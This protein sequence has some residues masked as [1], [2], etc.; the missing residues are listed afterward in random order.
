MSTPSRACLVTNARAAAR[1]REAEGET[2]YWNVA[3]DTAEPV[4][5]DT[6]RVRRRPGAWRRYGA[7]LDDRRY[8][9]AFEKLPLTRTC[10][11][12]PAF[13]CTVTDSLAELPCRS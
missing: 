9:A 3:A 10:T 4:E 13:T 7:R 1:R 12:S 8:F 5:E 2:T 11:D 6:R